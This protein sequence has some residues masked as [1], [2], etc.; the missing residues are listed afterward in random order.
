MNLFQCSGPANA[1]RSSWRN[2][3]LGW[4]SKTIEPSRR[5]RG[6]YGN[7]KR[8]GNILFN[9]NWRISD[10]KYV[11]NVD[12][13]PYIKVKRPL[14]EFPEEDTFMVY[15][16][17]VKLVESE[18]F[19][20]LD[21]YFAAVFIFNLKYPSNVTKFCTFLQNYFLQIYDSG[22]SRAMKR[23]YRELLNGEAIYK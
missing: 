20:S 13:A 10:P 18:F 22:C 9:L 17:K 6:V 19:K 15:V 2:Y 23:L 12:P 1:E 16:D 3:S 11:R 21:I 7:R 5:G 4:L 8:Y 14:T